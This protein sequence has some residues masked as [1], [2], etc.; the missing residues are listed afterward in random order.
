MRA[1]TR[2][3]RKRQ[4]PRW[5]PKTPPGVLATPREFAEDPHAAQSLA[6]LAVPI[7]SSCIGTARW[8]QRPEHKSILREYFS[9]LSALLP[10]GGRGF[11]SAAGDL[12]AHD[13]IGLQILHA[14][15]VY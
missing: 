7:A 15:I 13:R 12:F 1:A 11:I 10:W 3:A 14:V 4:R 2:F 5:I 9:S 6:A 8:R